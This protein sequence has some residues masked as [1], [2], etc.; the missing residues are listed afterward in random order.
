MQK[1]RS[2]P[3]HTQLDEKNRVMKGFL[4]VVI[5]FVAVNLCPV[6]IFADEVDGI[7]DIGEGMYDIAS[8]IVTKI[9][10]VV[11]ML[12]TIWAG[13]KVGKGEREAIPWAL[14]AAAGTILALNAESIKTWFEQLAG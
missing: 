5:L 8:T 11:G 10:P 12:L 7:S 4:L 14:G 2:M 1:E 3:K 6:A 13:V 9:I